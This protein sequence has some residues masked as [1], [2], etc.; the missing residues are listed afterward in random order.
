MSSS[1]SAKFT[2][3]ELV[4]LNT[5]TTLQE[6]KL[7]RSETLETTE[8]TQT[9]TVEDIEVIQ[10]QAYDEAFQQGITEGYKQGY[11]EGLKQGNIEGFEVGKKQGYNE[12]LHLLETQA[13][14][15]VELMTALSEPFQ[16]LDVKVE[17]QLVE[18]CILI[19]KQ[20]LRQEIQTQPELILQLI[21]ETIQ[22]LPIANQ[23]ITLTLHPDDAAV[24]RSMNM[25]EKQ[26]TW[27]IV[28]NPLL[29]QGGCEVTTETSYIDA[30]L[31]QR[32]NTVI[33]IL[34]NDD[35]AK[36]SST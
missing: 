9:L 24:L 16:Q 23:N 2:D 10:K 3:A 21:R 35:N 13:N 34:F 27:R 1:K 7:P 14:T 36:L 20:I 19:A 28:E 18:L 6:F 12:N 22:V 26:N 15:F 32:I 30:S 11:A 25:K 4:N 5:W 29:S 31:E 33:Q 17:Q 8:A